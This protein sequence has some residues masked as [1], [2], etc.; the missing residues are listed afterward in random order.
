MMGKSVAAFFARAG[1][2]HDLSA[3][4]WSSASREEVEIYFQTQYRLAQ[5][6]STV[7][8][9]DALEETRLSLTIP[10]RLAHDAIR[11]MHV[12]LSHLPLHRVRRLVFEHDPDRP[13]HI[14]DDSHG[15]TLLQALVLQLAYV[16]HLSI[17]H[18]PPEFF[19]HLVG[20]LGS[21][22]FDSIP[23]PDLRTITLDRIPLGDAPTSGKERPQS[24]VDILR[25]ALLAW[26][27]Q[28]KYLHTPKIQFGG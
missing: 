18:W 11:V 12:L 14:E 23:L 28:R 3:K 5:D 8:S 2:P 22:V 27:S 1:T 21:S 7:S 4:V 10:T 24:R 16:D 15:I 6:E 20:T 26:E 9:S 19:E 13:V 17:V 25:V